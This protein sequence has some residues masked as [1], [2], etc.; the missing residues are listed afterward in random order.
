MKKYAVLLAGLLAA[1]TIAWGQASTPPPDE[2]PERTQQRGMMKRRIPGPGGPEEMMRMK[3][4]RD[5]GRW[6]KDAHIVEELKL[7]PA[8]V[9]QAEE[10]FQTNR[11]NLIDLHANLEKQE[12]LLQPMM[13][14]DQV[15]EAKIGA[16][17]DQMLAARGRLE[18]ANVMMMLG[19]RKILSVEQWK[20]LEAIQHEHEGRFE[21]PAPP[22]PA[23]G[24]HQRR[25]GEV[26]PR[27]PHPPEEEDRPINP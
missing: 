11:L 13:E 25:P 26:M 18:K 7:T 8:Q 20:K 23:G 1:P 12:A 15:D 6:W 22:P 17:V 5:M 14:A 27:T 24:W 4:Q 9:S 10:K 3:R 16:Q 2:N 21:M 19:I